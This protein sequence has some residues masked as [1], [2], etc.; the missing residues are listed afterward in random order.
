MKIEAIF[1]KDV[2]TTEGWSQLQGDAEFITK[3]SKLLSAEEFA[4]LSEMLNS[5]SPE[6][7]RMI[8]QANSELGER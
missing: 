7:F 8:N 6:A 2:Y 4:H 5:R 3:L 1:K